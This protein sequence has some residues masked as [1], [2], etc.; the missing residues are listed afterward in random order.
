MNEIHLSQ[1]YAINLAKKLFLS[2]QNNQETQTLRKKLYYVSLNRLQRDLANN[3]LKIIFW[4][5]I[6]AAFSI[7]LENKTEGYQLNQKL[8]QIKIARTY[9]SLHDIEHRILKQSKLFSFLSYF[10]EAPYTTF[11]KTMAVSK[12]DSK[13]T[14]ILEQIK[15]K[16]TYE[17]YF[18]KPTFSSGL[19]GIPCREIICSTNEREKPTKNQKLTS[20]RKFVHDN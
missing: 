16:G 8:K 20:Y 12:Y 17:S 14:L 5:N 1:N 13:T 6:Y 10:G 2:T 4:L 7:I 19:Q 15:R 3:E 11:L 9:I 18:Y